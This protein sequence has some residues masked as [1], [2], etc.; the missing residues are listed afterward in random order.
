MTKEEFESLQQE[1]IWKMDLENQTSNVSRGRSI[2][3]GT[4]FGVVELTIRGNGER[5][6]WV[7]LNNQ[8]VTDLIHQ[9]A[10]GIGCQ[11][12]IIKR[13]DINLNIKV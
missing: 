9:L 4:A 6:L 3:C 13:Q 12:D 5:R 7:H 1:L 10:A 8:E 11:V 2:T